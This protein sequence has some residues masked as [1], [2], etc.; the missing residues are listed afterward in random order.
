M[1]AELNSTR[2][3][4]PADL[5]IGRLFQ[6]V[7]DAVVVVDA[8]DGRIVL[9]NPTAEA[10]FGYSADEALA[11]PVSVLVPQR[12][13]A[14]H[15]A[16]LA[17][18]RVT[19]HG[20][21][22]DGDGAVEVPARHKSGHEFMVELSLNPIEE[23]PLGGRF[24]MAIIRDVT[25]RT[26]LRLESERQLREIES[27]YRADAVLHRSLRLEDVLQGLVDLATDIMGADKST[28]L[29]WD[30]R[31]ERLVPGA[32][33]GFQPESIADLSF[34]PGEGIA[35]L[36]ATTGRAIAVEDTDRDPRVA[37][38]ITQRE[39]ISSF[40]HVPVQVSGEPFGVFGVHYTSPHTFTSDEQRMLESLA[41]RAALAI[42]NARLHER[43]QQVA[44]LEE[45]QRLARELHD[46]VT[47]TLF[48]ASLIAETLPSVWRL[49]H[50]RGE[51][52]L[53]D[54]RRLTWGALAEM[55]TLLLELRPAAL[56]EA[57][58]TDL[59]QQL[60]QA[61][62]ARGDLEVSTTATGQA[63]LP[64]HVH[65]AVYRLAQEALNNVVKHAQARR[66]E[67]E[68]RVNPHS[69]HLSVL[70]DG[71]GFDVGT[72]RADHFGLRIMRERAEAIG[73]T[74]NVDSRHGAG[75][76]VTVTWHDPSG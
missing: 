16:G 71:C 1:T 4:A 9:W 59:V 3:L 24:V 64:D 44:T 55:R 26:R 62:A 32:A 7:R 45:R 12:L 76:R 18:Y 33:R 46:A 25:E 61:T 38:Q 37:H 74:L 43:A 17:R 27:L 20:R 47:Q 48:A 75:T 52:S 36:V 40:L 50:E 15:R 11:M 6:H 68:L 73:A 72:V 19:G 28:V 67:V 63:R 30:A 41:Q 66:V 51:R 35:G 31:H 29:V 8:A 69:V 53:A 65:H 23:A 70:D 2:V 54:L 10:M 34:A 42:E 49:N 58:L 39:G 5:G 56:S 13:K 14:R 57:H 21:I 22:V 60:G